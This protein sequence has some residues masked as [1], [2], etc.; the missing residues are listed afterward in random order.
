MPYRNTTP[1]LKLGAGAARSAG[2][3]QSHETPTSVADTAAELRPGKAFQAAEPAKRVLVVEDEEDSRE[4]LRMLLE[5][6]GYV[7]ET[8]RN[9]LEGLAKLKGLIPD[10]AIVDIDLPGIDGYELAR[11]ARAAPGFG[12]IKL[13][14]LTG[15]GRDKDRRRAQQA[16][17][18]LH[19]T[20]PTSFAALRQKL[21]AD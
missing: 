13:I 4:G 18:D 19:L 6:S 10:I 17:F 12:R 15:F 20:K 7:V 2:L 1:L 14:A 3:S 8:A 16:G 5:A 9:G 21:E 11:R